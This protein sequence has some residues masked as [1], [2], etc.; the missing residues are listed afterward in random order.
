MPKRARGSRTDH[1]CQEAYEPL[2]GELLQLSQ[3]N[4][5]TIRGI[6]IADMSNHGASGVL[7]EHAQGDDREHTLPVFRP[8][9]WQ[10]I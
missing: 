8:R 3:K 7:N 2:W 9:F 4:G 1:G 6:W 10:I 5:F